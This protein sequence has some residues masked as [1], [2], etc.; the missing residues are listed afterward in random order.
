VERRIEQELLEQQHREEHDKDRRRRAE[1]LHKMRLKES[2]Q[3]EQ[4]HNLLQIAMTGMLAYMTDNQQKKMTIV[5]HL[6]KNKPG[7]P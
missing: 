2:R 4:F 6:K 7:T 5:G 3:Q 1:E